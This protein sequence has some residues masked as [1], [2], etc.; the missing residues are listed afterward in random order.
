MTKQLR[1]QHRKLFEY[2]KSFKSEDCPHARQLLGDTTYV[3]YYANWEVSSDE[4]RKE[5]DDM[6][7]WALENLSGKY[8]IYRG[9]GWFV[10]KEDAML[11]KLTWGT[12]R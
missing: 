12:Y 2:G 5:M 3:G 10:N 11:F 6:D 7:A 1:E 9:S 8:I 4:S